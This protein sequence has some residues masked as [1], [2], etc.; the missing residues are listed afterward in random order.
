ML[1][2]EKQWIYFWVTEIQIGFILQIMAFPTGI[3]SLRTTNSIW[4]ILIK[5]KMGFKSLSAWMLTKEQVKQ[6]STWRLLIT[7]HMMIWRKAKLS[8]LKK[9]LNPSGMNTFKVTGIFH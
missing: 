2:V 4:K 1:M 5:A 3:V 8:V 6:P 9:I 7:H